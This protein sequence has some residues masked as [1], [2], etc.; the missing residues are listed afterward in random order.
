MMQVNIYDSID[1]ESVH[2]LE[3]GPHLITLYTAG[4]F[5]CN[6]TSSFISDLILKH[7]IISEMLWIGSMKWH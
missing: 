1:H 6:N 2:H 3:V 4:S 5:I 7:Y